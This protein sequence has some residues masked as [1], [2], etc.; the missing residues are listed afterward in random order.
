VT[1]ST[2][3]GSPPDLL[4]HR[5]N[6]LYSV[7]DR[8]LPG[9]WGRLVFGIGVSH[10]HFF[11]EYVWE[12]AR[13]EGHAALPSRMNASFAFESAE[14]AELFVLNDWPTYTYAVAVADPGV[15]H[16]RADTSWLDMSVFNQLH[17]FEAMGRL[18]HHYWSGDER[19]GNEWEWL[20]AGELSVRQRLTPIL[21]DGMH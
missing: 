17:S 10:T 2:P 12:H 14:R 20:F 11:R 8:I 6:A 7:G 5:S 16:H 4:F 19:S 15:P 1:A 21:D 9:N 13:V 18:A 3:A